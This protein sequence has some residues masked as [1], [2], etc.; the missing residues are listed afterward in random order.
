ADQLV[1]VGEVPGPEDDRG[2]HYQRAPVTASL[3]VPVHLFGGQLGTAVVVH[4]IGHG[5]LVGWAGVLAVHGHRG[6]EAQVGDAVVLH[7]GADRPRPTDVYGL[8]G[9]GTDAEVVVRGGQV[10]HRRTAG[11]R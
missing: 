5:V 1:Q 6:V 3:P 11:H 2:A 4:R 7:G 10:E 9:G 8:E